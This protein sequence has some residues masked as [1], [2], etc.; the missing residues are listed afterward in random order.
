MKNQQDKKYKFLLNKYLTI[1]LNQ[2]ILIPWIKFTNNTVI[3]LN[4]K[5]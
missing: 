1:V 5:K 4:N 2:Y 3:Y